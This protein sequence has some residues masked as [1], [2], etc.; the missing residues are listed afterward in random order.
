MASPATPF[1]AN[2]AA[3]NSS[4]NKAL[5]SAY[6]VVGFGLL[7]VILIGIVSYIFIHGFYLVH[8]SWVV[9][10]VISPNDPVVLDLRARIA[11]EDWMR[12]KVLTER[13]TLEV[14][15]KKAKRVAE[16]ENSF[17]VFFKRAMKKDAAA[18]RASL[19]QLARVR[20]EQARIEVEMQG[21]IASLL[22]PA[23][24]KVKAD[25][26]AKLI[27]Q[28]QMLRENLELAQMAQARLSSS[29]SR[30]DLD[31]KARQLALEVAAFET[32]SRRFSADDEPVNYAG[33]ALQRE[34]E[35]SMNEAL[36]AR[37]E[38]EALERG[39][40]ELDQSVVHYDEILNTLE[41]SPLLRATQAK[42]ALAFVP[43]DNEDRV[44]EGA[45]VYACSLGVLFCR[46]VGRIQSYWEGEVKQPHPVYGRELRGQ[47]AELVLEDPSFAK[48]EVL[49]VNRAPLL[50]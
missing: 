28:D 46:K 43:Y 13:A 10:T 44:V 24:K 8:R 21:V 41:E 29:Q 30:L 49:H 31:E 7:T 11:H 3:I 37:D 6:K 45:P 16:L 12:H 4:L 47:L 50:L 19:E 33:L 32:A 23:R 48:Y 14:Q 20:T 2:A 42:L 40:D 38:V 25:F 5:V 34:N 27:D 22:E 17:Q 15:L 26:A 18:R 35:A 1:R 9:P 39:L 36:G